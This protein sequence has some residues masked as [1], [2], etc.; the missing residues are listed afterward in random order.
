MTEKNGKRTRKSNGEGSV[1][2]NEKRGVWMAEITWTDKTKQRHSKRFSDKRQTGVKFK[3]SE[4]KKQLILDQGSVKESSV[5]FKEYAL[6]WMDTVQK[7]KLK[8][9]S[10]A[11]KMVTL[12]QQ[13]FPNIGMI[14]IEMLTVD[15]IQKFINK[16]DKEGLSYSTI[17]KAYEAVNGCIK[18]YI[19]S[20]PQHFNPCFG[21]VLPSR[22][23]KS[24]S[25]I[26]YF[27]G[28]EIVKIQS[29][30]IRTFGNGRPVFRYGYLIVAFMYTGLRLGE[31]L[32]LTWD[33]VD[34]ENRLL[35]VNKSVVRTGRG[36]E[37]H[38]VRYD[39]IE[40][41]S[42]KTDSGCRYVPLSDAALD[43][44]QHLKKL[45]RNRPYVAST[46]HGTHPNYHSIEHMLKR[47]LLSEGIRDEEHLCGVHSLRHTFASM[48]F[49]NGCSVKVVSELLGHS[50][51][52]ITEDI[53]IHLIQKQKVTAVE[54]LNKYSI[55]LSA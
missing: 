55:P 25:K 31:M 42:T 47:I 2:F 52:K 44:F 40:Q 4:F 26:N 41:D 14:P 29:A 15:D 9:T 50:N 1:W 43:A 39:Y 19:V 10:Y 33:D 36:Y 20:N 6:F 5:T 12:E 45:D 17:K 28:E 8:P 32:A 21:V 35:T 22:K 34:F 53:Y 37:D 16:L 51:T 46:I 30:A 7:N 54:E 11:R 49:A 38:N 27:Q 23:R 3:L 48:L 13:V 18:R 24:V